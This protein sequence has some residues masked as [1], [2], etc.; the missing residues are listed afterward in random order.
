[1]VIIFIFLFM[2]SESVE[3]NDRVVLG[4]FLNKHCTTS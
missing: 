4:V 1:M 2:F 3:N